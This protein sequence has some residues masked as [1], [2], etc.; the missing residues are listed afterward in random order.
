VDRREAAGLRAHLEGCAAC[1]AASANLGRVLDSLAS[2]SRVQIEVDVTA[3]VMR[4]VR[5]AA[6]VPRHAFNRAA[7]WIVGL[8]GAGLVAEGAWAL[9]ALMARRGATRPLQPLESAW[10]LLTDILEVAAQVYLFTLRVGGWISNLAGPA[11][12]RFELIAPY[13]F[14]TALASLTLLLLA[15][16]CLARYRLRPYYGVTR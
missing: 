7:L 15:A 6:L 3:R 8:A 2:L 4:E 1:R 12:E 14:M 5:R 11:V 13:F 9:W 10:A 16:L